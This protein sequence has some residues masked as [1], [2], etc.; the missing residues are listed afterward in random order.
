M[1]AGADPQQGAHLYIYPILAVK[2]GGGY[3][4]ADPELFLD[5]GFQYDLSVQVQGGGGTSAGDCV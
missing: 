4:G 5:R 3:A 2:G 1:G